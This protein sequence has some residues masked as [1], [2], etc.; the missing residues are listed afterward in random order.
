M[1]IKT[2]L[3]PDRSFLLRLEKISRDIL[4]IEGNI[5]RLASQSESG[6]IARHILEQQLQRKIREL[7]YL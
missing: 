3:K 6:N 4:T 5:N 2:T 1:L 7:K